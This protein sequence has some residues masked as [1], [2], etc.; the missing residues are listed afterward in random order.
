MQKPSDEELVNIVMKLGLDGCRDFTSDELKTDLLFRL[1]RG[2]KAIEAMEKLNAAQ[3]E[4]FDC[5]E[6]GK[7][8][9]VNTSLNIIREYQHE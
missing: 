5:H 8:V 1:E 6:M 4:Y 2:R 9:F 7:E 3:K